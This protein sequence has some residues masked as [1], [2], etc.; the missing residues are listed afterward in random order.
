M[1]RVAEGAPA[2]EL[3]VASLAGQRAH[4]GGLERLVRLERR[5][6]A[7]QARRQ[8]RLAR[9]GRADHQEVMAA[10]RRDLEHALGGLL[11]LDLGEVGIGR[12]ASSDAIACGRGRI[13]WPRRWLISASSEG[14][15]TISTCSP[16]HAASPPQAAGQIRPRPAAR[17]AAPPAARPAP[18]VSE[19]SS[20]SSPSATKLGQAVLRDH[21]HRRQQGRAR[22]AGRSGCPPWRDRPARG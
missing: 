3:A 22:S 16:A 4:H 20:A 9:A 7:G 12:R 6:D 14:A 5:Q 15:A 17:R 13:C 19:P 10:G 21:A 11:A 2:R 18:G 8:H 1:M